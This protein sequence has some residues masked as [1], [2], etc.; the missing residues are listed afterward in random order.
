ML[1]FTEASLLSRTHLLCRI[2][3]RLIDDVVAVVFERVVGRTGHALDHADEHDVVGRIDP[4]P[5]SGGA[6]PE[7]CA[8]AVG[9]VGLGG[10]KMTA[11]L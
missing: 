9:E 2:D 5:C 4:E 6:I 10:S 8:L 1:A 3:E 11:Q 7:E